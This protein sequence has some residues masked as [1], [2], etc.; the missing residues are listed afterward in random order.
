MLLQRVEVLVGHDARLSR[1]EPNLV[2]YPELEFDLGLRLLTSYCEF[3]KSPGF[4][5]NEIDS[6]Q[7]AD[8]K[9]TESAPGVSAFPYLHYYYCY[10]YYY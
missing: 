9:L 3:M 1:W 6:L 8:L 4:S 10:Y 7:V 2:Q 5:T